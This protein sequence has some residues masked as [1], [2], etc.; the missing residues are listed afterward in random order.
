V[1]DGIE[2]IVSSIRTLQRELEVHHE[3][4]LEVPRA[5]LDCVLPRKIFEDSRGYLIQV[6]DQINSCYDHACYDACAVMIRRLV[7]V[8]I[9]ETFD[10]HG[11]GAEI[12]DSSGNYFFLDELTNKMLASVRWS[13][14]RTTKAGL[15]KLK[16]MG[17]QSAHSR[18]YNAK[19]MYVDDAVHD[20]RVVSE[21]LLYL[22]G[23]RK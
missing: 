17:D 4:P 7:E 23:L 20:L 10:H 11:A 14:G 9:I 3:R 19:R 13:L 15:K 1:S 21:E 18:R 22:A 5:R 12:T 6:V 16:T 8:L 2:H